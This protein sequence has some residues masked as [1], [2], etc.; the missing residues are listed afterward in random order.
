MRE[1][2]TFFVQGLPA[3][4]PR[5]KATRRGN[6]AGVYTPTK[7]KNAKTGKTKAH[8]A[9]T[10]KLAI[11]AFIRKLPPQPLWD[12]PLRVDL[13]FYFPRP[14]SHFRSNGTLKPNAPKWHVSKPDRDNSD[15]LVLDALTFKKLDHESAEAGL[16]ADDNIV[17]DGRV[18]KL[19]TMTSGLFDEMQCAS[20]CEITIREAGE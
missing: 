9:Y 17:C 20:G 18:Q 19:Y 11:R 10:W 5:V 13:T 4:Q 6:H 7:I 2:L 14:A 3:G 16:W 1:P 12:G 8:P 15:K